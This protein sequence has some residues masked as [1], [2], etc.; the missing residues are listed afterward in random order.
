L[1]QSGDTSNPITG[2]TGATLSLGPLELGVRVW[3]EGLQPHCPL[4]SKPEQIGMVV[5][6]KT[7]CVCSTGVI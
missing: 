6:S 2:A 5:L 4:P 1:G 3:V 7:E